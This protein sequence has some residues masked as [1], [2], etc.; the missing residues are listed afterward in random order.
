MTLK[1]FHLYADPGPDPALHFDA[2][3]DPDTAFRF[4]ADAEPNP[5]PKM[6]RIR[7]TGWDENYNVSCNLTAEIESLWSRH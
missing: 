7:N 3:P 2:D 5:L 6:I 4:E 1:G